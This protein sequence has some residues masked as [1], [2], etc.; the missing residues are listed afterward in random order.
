MISTRSSVLN[1]RVSI[2]PSSLSLVLK[3]FA[4]FIEQIF[5]FTELLN[6]EREA[7]NSISLS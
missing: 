7:E 3:F 6:F 5:C 2:I 1:C 4:V